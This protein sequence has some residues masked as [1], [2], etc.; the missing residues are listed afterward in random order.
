M[1]FRKDFLWG[2][3]VAAHQLE[4]A[5]DRDGKG[6]SIM[7]VVTSGDVNTRR[8]ITGEILKGENYPN[9]E[10]IDFYDYYKEDIRLF[11]EMGFKCFRTSIAWTRIFPNGDEEQPNEAG[12]KF[13]DDM[14]DEC[15]KCGIEPVITLSHFEMP[16][17]LV[18]E[19]GGWRNRKLIDFFV[20]FAVTCF[21]RYKDKVK[22]WM[23]FNEINNQADIGDGFMLYANSGVVVKP[24]EN[25][26]ELMYQASHY[27]LVASAEAIKAGHK[28]N[29]E[30]QI[31]CMIAMCPIYPATC[32]P[33]DILQAEKAMQKRYYYADVHVKGE[34]PVNILKYWERKDLKI[35]VTEEDLSVLK[36]GCVDYIGFSY[37]MSFCT[38]AEPDNPEYD[39]RGEKDRIKNQY[40]KTSEWGWQID[41]IGLRYSLNW[42]T[43]R[44]KVPLF[45]VENGFGAYDTLEEDGSI[46]DPYRVEYLQHHI[47]EMKKAVEEDGVDLGGRRIIKKIDLVSAG[48]G[49]MDKRYG[50]IYVEK[51]NDGTGD[52]SRRKKDSFEWY[53]EV[54]STNGEN[55]N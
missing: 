21:E 43:D 22:Y 55:I 34:Y 51:H 32:R 23:T 54:I 6:L 17:Y 41:P 7:D 29:P 38:K 10:A 47:S 53:K 44:Y 20:K 28:I 16:L 33:E 3:A 48:S 5:Y 4:G 13:Y 40:V 36:Q 24:E 9:H 37:Y 12:L 1:G 31:G 18:Q 14:F 19:Y 50:F 15:L 27:E 25:V 26:E 46:H 42:F 39:Y 52:L 8:R 35:D 11:A 49:E 2:G 30:F 45:I